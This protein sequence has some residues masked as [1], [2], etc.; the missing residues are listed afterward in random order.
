MYCGIF[1]FSGCRLSWPT[2]KLLVDPALMGFT[3]EAGGGGEDDVQTRDQGRVKMAPI[4]P[5]LEAD[6]ESEIRAGRADCWN[7]TYSIEIVG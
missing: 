7:G 1:R 6:G 4:P 2:D 5:C 3:G